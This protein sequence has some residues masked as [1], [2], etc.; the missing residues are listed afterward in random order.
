MAVLLAVILLVL[1]A[2]IVILLG[3]YV[4]TYLLY[5]IGWLLKGKSEII[6][7]RVVVA[8]SMIPVLLKLPVILYLGL[9]SKYGTMDGLENWLIN[10]FYIA[11]WIWAM[12]IMIQGLIRFNRYGIIKAVINTLPFIVLSWIPLLIPYLN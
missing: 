11:L 2:A 3:Q 5:A 12:K 9:N 4:L 1:G 7:I 6:D 8:Y 10:G